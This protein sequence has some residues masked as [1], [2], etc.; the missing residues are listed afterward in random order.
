MVPPF[1]NRRSQSATVV[2]GTLLIALVACTG[3]SETNNADTDAAPPRDSAGKVEPCESHAPHASDLPT[4]FIDT[5]G[6]EIPDEP[7]VPALLEV[8]APGDWFAA[9]VPLLTSPIGI[10]IRGSSSRGHRKLSYGFELLDAEGQDKPLPVLGLPEASDWV[11]YGPFLDPSAMRNV[12]AYRLS[13]SIGRWAPRTKYVELYVGHRSRPQYSDFKGLYVLTERTDRGP[14]RIDIFPQ[15][16]R[17]TDPTL[18]S[19]GY[20]VR[21]DRTR[22][23]D[24]HFRTDSGQQVTYRYPKPNRMSDAQKDWIA[25]YV[26]A[27]ERSLDSRSYGEFIDVD[28]FVDFALIQELSRNCDAYR[29]S[30]YFH[31]DR[32]HKLVAGP[33]WD[34]NIAFGL[35]NARCRSSDGWLTRGSSNLGHPWW[36]ALFYDPLFVDR[37]AKRWRELRRQHLSDRRIS[38]TID[39]LA[40]TVRQGQQR[41]VG[42]W[43]KPGSSACE[44]ATYDRHLAWLKDWIRERTAWIDR[45]IDTLRVP[46]RRGRSRLL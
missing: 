34:F 4:L 11:L 35:R 40:E 3:L 31:K 6:A 38:A 15:Q 46:P 20:I 43:Q 9:N 16:D 1:D 7:K 27:F 14:G 39:D 21:I 37:F 41:D 24:T 30:T 22:P 5:G 17:E 8:H 18:I 28:S 23:G 33:V 36:N 10:E 2:L 42:R 12:L 45:N 26:R 29:V 25:E 32:G 44:P 19:G 13:R